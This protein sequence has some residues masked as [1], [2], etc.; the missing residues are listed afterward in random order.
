[1]QGTDAVISALGM[2]LQT[3]PN[4]LMVDATA[5]LIE[6]SAQTGVPRLVMMSSWGV[7]DTL[8]RSSIPVR[9]TYWA[10]RRVHG[11]KAVA[12]MSLRASTLDWTLVYP[13]AL[14]N[15]R[16]SGRV[17]ARDLDDVDRMRGMPRISRA[18][19]AA[20]LVATAESGAWSRRTVVVDAQRRRATEG[21]LG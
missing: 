3:T 16:P 13:V 19:V 10:G 15:G 8:R 20:F 14:T 21:R 7:G 18:D 12:E 4:G 11:E 6:A 1:M 2:G 17:R 5:A 9:L